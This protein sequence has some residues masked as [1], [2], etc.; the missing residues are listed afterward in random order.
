MPVFAMC[1]PSINTEGVE[2]LSSQGTFSQ[3][4]Q[5]MVLILRAG[6]LT[7]NLHMQNAAFPIAK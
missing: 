3:M 1:N 6:A 7:S 4:S 2:A 5:D